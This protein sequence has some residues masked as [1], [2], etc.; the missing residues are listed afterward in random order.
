MNEQQQKLVSDYM[1]LANKIAWKKSL[2]TPKNV[3]FDDLKSAA[4]MGLIDAA[5][6]FNLEKCCDFAW[7]ARIRISGAIQDYLKNFIRSDMIRSEKEESCSRFEEFETEDFFDFVES[8]L[9]F[10]EGKILHMYY[11]EGR[12]LKEIGKS[13]GVSESRISQLLG[14][15]HKRLKTC[16]TK[17]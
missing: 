17:G 5:L 3:T 1:P 8:H 7:Y 2:T 13:R 14:S 4:Y 10:E 12:T 15:C 16:L 9:P 6:K 11:V